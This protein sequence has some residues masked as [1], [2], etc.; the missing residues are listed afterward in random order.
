VH[1]DDAAHGVA[2]GEADVV[3]EAA[4]QER[5]RQLLLVVRGDDDD[6][7]LAGDHRLLGLV[8]VELHAVKL[9]QQIVGELDVGLVDL[10]D[11]QDRPDV[12]GERLPQAAPDDVVAD[13]VHAR[14]AELRV[15]QPGHRVVFV[16]PLLRLRRGFDVP[17]DQRRRQRAGDL[18]S[19]NRLAR[20]RLAL[21]QKRTFER[22]RRVDRDHQV[23]GRDVAVGA[24]EAR[25]HVACRPRAM[26]AG[27]GGRPLYSRSTADV[28]EA[29]DH[30]EPKAG[31]LA[32]LDQEI[33]ERNVNRS[34]REQSITYLDVKR[35]GCCDRNYQ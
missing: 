12:A 10:V 19:E 5:V 32:D 17:L 9:E 34:H 33:L 7:P 30:V 4:P 22:D 20:A 13:V 26:P 24:F 11:Q 28:S 6:R 2:V 8:D 21:D 1:V 15:A 25:V 14:L 29:A 27:Y 31:F 3:E 18:I 23:F 35:V 16:E